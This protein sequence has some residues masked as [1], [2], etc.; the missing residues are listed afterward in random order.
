M[1]N[2]KSGKK[3]LGEKLKKLFGKTGSD[4]EYFEELEDALIESDLGVK[5][6]MEIVDLLRERAKKDRLDKREDLAAAVKSI[7][8]GYIRSVR[9]V[10]SGNDL[11]VY[12][13][14][15]VNGVG[16]T[17]TIAKMA[18]YYRE[19][20]DISGIVFSAADTF[21]AAAIDQLKMHA[22]RLDF[23]IVHQQSGSD[24]AAVIFDTVE[25]ALN[26]KER[27]ILAD[28]AGRM[29]NRIDLVGELQ[30]IDKII[31]R[32]IDE[33]N[34][35]KVLIIDA[36]TGQNGLRQAEIFHDAIGV[37]AL[38]LSKY[39]STARGGI[40]V[41]MCR[42]LSIPFA[43]LGTGEKSDSLKPFDSEEYLDVL[44]GLD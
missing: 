22:Q 1:L 44:L 41:P 38:V 36:T 4:D 33:K 9:L 2:K 28:T 16:K 24:P 26:R 27:L 32:K 6:A 18:H 31:R 14:L 19:H 17:T 21:R 12:L 40:V 39:D 13:I 35:R 3:L 29:H 42:E 10:P 30:K 5:T 8:S 37:D 34:Y 20:E 23:R 7:L 25:S 15:G 11:H 43:F